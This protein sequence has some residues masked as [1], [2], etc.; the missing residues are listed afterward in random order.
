MSESDKEE[1][2]PLS[3]LHHPLVDPEEREEGII[4]IPEKAGSGSSL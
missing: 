4:S 1:K 2:R 3:F